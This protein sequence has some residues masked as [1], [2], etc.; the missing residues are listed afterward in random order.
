[1]STKAS[2]QPA[3]GGRLGIDYRLFRMADVHGFRL[4]AAAGGEGCHP[5]AAPRVTKDEF[6]TPGEFKQETQK[7]DAYWKAC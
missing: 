2:H 5:G 7:V 1:M 3:V 6:A 4:S